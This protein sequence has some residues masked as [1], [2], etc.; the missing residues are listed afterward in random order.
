L[1]NSAASFER[2]AFLDRS[3]DDLRRVL[4]VN[5]IAGV[6]LVRRLAGPLHDVR[7]SVVNILDLGAHRPWKGRLDHCV[8]KAAL[9][10]ATESLAIELAP[11]RVNAVSPGTVAWPEGMSEADRAAVVRKIPLGDIGEPR[12]VADAVAYLA[13]AVHV[14]ATT[15]IVDGGRL[16]AGLG[17]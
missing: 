11:V 12:D 14:T 9:R 13:D 4:E 10:M 6:G 16:A 7:G 1:V 15:L 17:E 5:L 3:D 2:G 8:A